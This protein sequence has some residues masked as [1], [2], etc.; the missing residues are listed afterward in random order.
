[1]NI[2][3]IYNDFVTKLLPQIQQG[4]TIT[5]EYFG[6][7][8]GRYIK[9]LIITNSIWAIIGLI[10][11]ITGIVLLIKFQKIIRESWG[12]YSS[13]FMGIVV[14]FIISIMII[15]GSVI[16]LANVDNLIKD[17]YIPEVRIIEIISNYNND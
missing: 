7:L 3:T 13:E 8:F 17:I 5:K 4:L 11:F 14:P 2:D 6:D 9:Y 16:F 10:L 1:M 12:N 15:S